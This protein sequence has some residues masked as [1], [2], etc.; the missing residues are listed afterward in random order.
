MV[1]VRARVRKTPKP[2]VFAQEAM[3]AGRYTICPIQNH[4]SIDSSRAH[5][6]ACQ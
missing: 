5:C 6:C 1:L 2:G 3:H 4:I